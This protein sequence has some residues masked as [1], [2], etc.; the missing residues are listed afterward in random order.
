MEQDSAEKEIKKGVT[1]IDK[2]IQY[3]ATHKRI[4]TGIFIVAFLET[5]ISPIFPELVV[6][7]VLSYRKDISWKLLSI[8]SA[9]GSTLGAGA[10]YLL[11]KFLYKT[12]ESFFTKWLGTSFGAYTEGLFTHNT[13]VSTFLAAFTS[14]PDR[15]FAFFSGVFLLSFPVVLA[16]FFL[17]RLIRVGIVAYFSYEFGDEAR[18][19]ILKHTKWVTITLVILVA[20]YILL[21]VR[22]IL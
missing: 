22:G 20:V 19:Y 1:H 12:Y 3:V 17:G 15:I 9:L 5:T 11:G 2:W 10:V 16:A 4:K 6:A 13:F 21:K 8:I 14:I 7:A 18:A